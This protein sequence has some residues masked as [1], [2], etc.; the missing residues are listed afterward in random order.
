MTTH[1][2]HNSQT[3]TAEA[4]ANEHSLHSYSSL[5]THTWVG[6]SRLDKLDKGNELGSQG[7][8]RPCSHYA[9]LAEYDRAIGTYVPG[10]VL[11]VVDR[12]LSVE[13]GLIDLVLEL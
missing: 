4:G 12:E 2:S 10:S 7:R 11:E 9:P 5:G 6:A 3:Y 8:G 1:F 13:Q